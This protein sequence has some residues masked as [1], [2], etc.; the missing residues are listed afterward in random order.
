M[1]DMFQAGILTHH[2][3]KPHSQVSHCEAQHQCVL[4]TP[5]NACA[6]YAKKLWKHWLNLAE[7]CQ[8]CQVGPPFLAQATDALMSEV[9]HRM[10]VYLRLIVR[11]HAVATSSPLLAY[12]QTERMMWH[13]VEC[14]LESK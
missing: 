8:V 13:R 4:W 1:L 14:L 2:G 3:S 7:L 12:L 9:P 6:T 10:L 11:G 5:Q